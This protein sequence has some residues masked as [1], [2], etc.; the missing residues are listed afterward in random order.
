MKLLAL[1]ALALA[2]A[3][4]FAAEPPQAAVPT[5]GAA[6][7]LS[8]DYSAAES[9]IRAS[10]STAFD[11]GRDINLGIILAKTG[12]TAEAESRFMAVLNADEQQVTVASGAQLSSHDVARN[13]LLQLH[14]GDLSK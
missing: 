14:R 9:E 8:S 6:A 2:A 5:P 10:K 7:I 11:A 1:S 12:K 13:A 3:P 4:A